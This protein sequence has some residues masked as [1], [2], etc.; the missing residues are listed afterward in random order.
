MDWHV[1]AIRSSFVLGFSFFLDFFLEKKNDARKKKRRGALR[2][3][4]GPP[5]AA[6][7][8][9]SADADAGGRRPGRRRRSH[10]KEK[11]KNPVKLGKTA[12]ANEKSARRRCA[13]RLSTSTE[14]SRDVESH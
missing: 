1:H 11:K 14:F 9:S 5:L 6:G 13:G 10:E 12:L 3:R 2:P 7:V 8:V 4:A